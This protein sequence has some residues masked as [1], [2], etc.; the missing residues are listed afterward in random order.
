[1]GLAAMENFEFIVLNF[2]FFKRK[3]L[4]FYFKIITLLFIFGRK[5]R[6]WN[7]HRDRPT[8]LILLHRVIEYRSFESPTSCFF[9]V[10]KFSMASRYVHSVCTDF[11]HWAAKRSDAHP[12]YY[13]IN[14]FK[15]SE[16]KKSSREIIGL[17]IL[18]RICVKN[19]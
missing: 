14:F 13:A 1:M 16:N 4:C 19:T 5:F 12:T 7:A 10:F 17:R 11:R 6:I 9:T 15:K 3:N 18:H 2:R 8:T